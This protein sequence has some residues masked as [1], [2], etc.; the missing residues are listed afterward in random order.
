[1]TVRVAPSTVRREEH[2]TLI[3]RVISVSD[4]PVTFEAV[5]ALVQND[6]L[7]RSFMEGGPPHQVVIALERDPS[8]ASGYRWTSSRG[9]GVS[10]S[11][12]TALNA[13]ITVELRR[14]IGMVIPALR[15]IFNL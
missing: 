10:L 13:D 9:V 5:R 3:G 4:F 8:T 6:D 15:D 14:P 7:A 11:S 1:M 12:G 2:G